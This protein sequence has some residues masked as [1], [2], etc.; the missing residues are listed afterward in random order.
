MLRLSASYAGKNQQPLM[1]NDFWVSA[2]RM[3][4]PIVRALRESRARMLAT[5]LRLARTGIHVSYLTEEFPKAPRS[6]YKRWHGG[7]IKT[8]YLAETFPH[9][10]L[11][12]N[13]MYIVSS[14]YRGE[15]LPILRAAKEHGIKI[16]WNQNG[17]FYPAW[18]TGNYVE[19]NKVFWNGMQLAD[20]IIYQSEFCQRSADMWVGKPIAPSEIVYN[21]VDTNHFQ[22]IRRSPPDQVLKLLTTGTIGH[23]YKLEA[24][25]Q[26]V[27]IL[28]KRTRL[29]PTLIIAGNVRSSFV[30]AM[31][32]LSRRLGVKQIIQFWGPYT[33]VEAPKIYRE[34][35]VFVHTQY[36][37]ACPTVVVEALACGLP[38]VYS[39]SGGTPELVG[40]EAGIGVPAPLDW[41]H[42]FTP[43][44]E[45]LATAI[46]QISNQWTDYA[47][48]ARK[49]AVDRF[50]LENYVQQHLSIFQQLIS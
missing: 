49:R 46:F 22:P 42:N 32:S 37:D 17:V 30:R 50:S 44:P 31:Q 6:R 14:V 11:K 13:I 8:S 40:F 36:N 39:A 19:A 45:D 20:F 18:Y 1:D 38:V 25:I 5:K 16:I 48:A 23:F 7:A 41:E 34:A 33:Q 12:C 2:R 21:A 24:V 3:G 10:G 27:A 47:S 43:D 9:A 28:R 35:H 4:L 29:R 15:W 26:A